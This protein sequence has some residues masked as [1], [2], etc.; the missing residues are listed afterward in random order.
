MTALLSAVLYT[1]SRLYRASGEESALA[2]LLDRLARRALAAAVPP[3]ARWRIR[4]AVEQVLQQALSLADAPNGGWRAAVAIDDFRRAMLR[5]YAE[6]VAPPVR[7]SLSQ[8]LSEPVGRGVRPFRALVLPALRS[9]AEAGLSRHADPT[10]F[11]APRWLGTAALIDYLNRVLKLSL[12]RRFLD[13][14]ERCGLFWTLDGL[15]FAAERPSYFNWD[16]AGQLHCDVGPSLAYPSGWSWWHWHEVRVA[17]NVIEAP[18][19]IAVTA[20]HAAGSQA[21]RIM[22]ERYRAGEPV[23]GIAAYLHDSGAQLV[24]HDPAFGTLWQID[25]DAAAPILMLEVE[26]RSPEPDGTYRHFLL[27]VAPELRPLRRGGFGRWQF[28][29][30]RNAVASTFGLTGAEYAPL[31]ET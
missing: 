22:L 4:M 25:A 9:A 16:E 28:P 15:C 12:D 26:N 2:L 11:G 7:Q 31:I 29:T 21:R 20:I 8:L 10:C 23:S 14:V 17:Q 27:R 24:D 1:R 19:T 13:T 18:E 5:L 3:E 6:A 30:A